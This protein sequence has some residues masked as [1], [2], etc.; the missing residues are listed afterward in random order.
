MTLLVALIPGAN[1]RDELIEIS[2]RDGEIDA[3][4]WMLEHVEAYGLDPV[5]VPGLFVA[6]P[7][8]DSYESAYVALTDTLGGEIIDF[9]DVPIPPPLPPGAVP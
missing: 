9:E 8:W 7:G 5:E 3:P 2:W 6:T 4:Q 1:P